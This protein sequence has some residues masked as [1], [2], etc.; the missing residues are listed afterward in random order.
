M[1]IVAAVLA[2]I[3]YSVN[4][5]VVIYDRIRENEAQYPGLD[6]YTHI[7]NASNETLSRTIITSGATLIVSA[8]MYFLG[9]IAIKDFFLAMSLG[10][11]VGTYSSIF[12]ASAITV[13]VE[14]ILYSKKAK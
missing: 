14:K 13:W 8:A 11:I 7:N 2:I 12:I 4:D 1:Q 10:I 3:G 6:I 5:T 9:G